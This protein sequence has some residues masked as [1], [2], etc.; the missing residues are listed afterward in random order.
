MNT[1]MG[2][3]LTLSVLPLNFFW[4]ICDDDEIHKG[5]ITEGLTDLII[6]AAVHPRPPLP[7]NSAAYCVCHFRRYVT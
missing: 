6:T 3:L 2:P 7:I 5:N 1:D 4:P